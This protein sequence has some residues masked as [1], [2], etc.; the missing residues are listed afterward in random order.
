MKSRMIGLLVFL[1]GTIGLYAQEKK[2]V[3]QGGFGG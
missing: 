3:A 2:T 1:L